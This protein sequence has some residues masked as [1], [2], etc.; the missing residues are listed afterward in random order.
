MNESCTR[1]IMSL[2]GRVIWE[3]SDPLS[4]FVRRIWDS[5]LTA[6][7][8]QSLLRTAQ[9][10]LKL[11]RWLN[12][13]WRVFVRHGVAKSSHLSTVQLKVIKFCSLVP[14]KHCNNIILWLVRHYIPIWWGRNAHLWRGVPNCSIQIFQLYYQCSPQH[15]LG[16]ADRASLQYWYG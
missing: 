7:I 16:Q 8:S 2:T 9:L 14:N 5:L 13:F 4:M 12:D 11:Q 15:T 1:T 10:A 3:W 6:A